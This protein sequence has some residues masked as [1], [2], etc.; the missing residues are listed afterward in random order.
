MKE[1]TL[2]WYSESCAKTELANGTSRTTGKTKNSLSSTDSLFQNGS[3]LEDLYSLFKTEELVQM[4][5]AEI[6]ETIQETDKYLAQALK[7]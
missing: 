7:S 5:K 4:C 3:D 6:D 2:G 1:L